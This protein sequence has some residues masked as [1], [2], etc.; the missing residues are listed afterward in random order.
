MHRYEKL[1]IIVQALLGFILFFLR[2]MCI[3]I[4]VFIRANIGERY[5]NILHTL[6]ITATYLL[7]V[8]LTK[9]LTPAFE[10]HIVDGFFFISVILV[11][12]HVI[13]AKLRHRNGQEIHSYYGGTPI[14]VMFIP[15][16]ENFFRIYLEPILV[17]IIG[18]IFMTLG[19]ADYYSFYGLGIILMVSGVCML[20][21]AQIEAY[22]Q[23]QA[24]LDMLDRKIEADAISDVMKG[25]NPKDTKGF[26]ISGQKMKS[27]ETR[28]KLV[29]MYKGIDPSLQKM[30]EK[31]QTPEKT[32]NKVVERSNDKGKD[33]DILE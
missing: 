32:P 15:I 1:S 10:N 24:Y 16:N 8:G 13:A 29:D 19:E 21:K 33:M 28:Q 25:K 2:M 23:R 6:G 17:V 5:I 12:L 20:I 11:V 27:E 7:L 30:M 3:S 31:G 9:D 14:L 18:V 4:E 26:T 22:M